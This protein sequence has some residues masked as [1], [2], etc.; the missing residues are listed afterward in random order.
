MRLLFLIAISTSAWGQWA[1]FSTLTASTN[2]SSAMNGKPTIQSSAGSASGN[3]TA[4][5]DLWLNKSTGAAQPCTATNTWGAA[6]VVS[7]AD[8]TATGTVTKINGTSLAGLAT[9]ILKNTTTTGVPSIAAAGTDYVAPGGALGTPSSGTATNIT[10][11]P[12]STGV[13]GLGSGV[14]TF[15]ATPSGANFNSMISAGGIP[16]TQNSQSAAYTTVLSDGG[17]Q[18][19]HPTADNNARTFT[20]DSNANV[21]YPV[22]TTITFIN[23]INTVTIAI[24]SDTL[25]LAGSAT[26]GSRTLAAGGLATAIKVTSTLW[27]ISGSGLT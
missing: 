12:I 6:W 22:G 3:C 13:S 15:L 27:F 4:G 1:D 25:Q 14:A 21:A 24:T 7:G 19:L 18:I 9:G 23:Q 10:G 8:V 16:I 5:S 26:T 2:L 11:L 20:I 17:K